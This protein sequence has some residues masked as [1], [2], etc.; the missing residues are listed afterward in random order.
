MPRRLRL[1]FRKHRPLDAAGEQ[2]Q[3]LEEPPRLLLRFGVYAGLALVVAALVGTWLARHNATVRAERDVYLDAL[4]TAD[5]LGRDDL[6]KLALKRPVDAGLLADL[7]ELFSRAALDRGVLRVTLFSRDGVVTYSTDHS[8]IGRPS[9]DRALVERALTGERVHRTARLRGGFGDNPKV[10]QSYAPVYWY[11][12]KDSS[13]NGVVGVYREYAPV[14]QAIHDQTLIQGGTILAALLI[15][16]GLSFPILRS[17]TRTLR[18]RNR[19]LVEQAEALRLSEEQYRLIVETAAEGVALVDGEGSIV[20]ANR[21]LAELLGRRE[22]TLA[23]VQLTTMMD[24]HSRAAADPRW[25]RHRHREREFLFL[26]P[27]GSLVATAVSANPVLDRDGR[28]TGALVMVMDVSEQ[29]RIR[30]ALEEMEERLGAAPAAQELRSAGVM[31]RDFD[32]AL[33]AITGYGD[34]LLN[35]LDPSDPLWREASQL[36]ATAQGAVGLTRQLLAI[37]RRESLRSE[38]LD[39]S[40]LLAEFAPN[41]PRMVAGDGSIEVVASA[42][43]HLWPVRAD[44]AQVEQV[45]V[46]IALYSAR[47]MREGGRLAI[48]THNVTVDEQ[49]A[50]THRPMRPGPWVQLA[51]TDSGRRLD[52]EERER[53][54]RPLFVEESEDGAGLGLATVYGIVKQNEGFIWVGDAP[55]GAGTTFTIYLPVAA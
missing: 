51:I 47:S 53:L 8:L 1:A 31:A 33:I 23:G 43:P 29:T 16:Y 49:F 55:D 18:A 42:E 41:L 45:L 34:Y 3:R 6:A 52:S 26:R 39:L 12:D 46:N 15:L 54:F 21:K 24:E 11:F 13:P 14:A 28:Y 50:A 9:Y 38:V 7:D 36:R 22:E 35:R 48:E 2:A 44:A 17:V 10:I 4:H 30:Q 40:A 20:F 25:F 19:Q 32:R 37:S 27:D 5:R